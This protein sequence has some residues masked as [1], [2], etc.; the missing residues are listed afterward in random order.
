MKSN[1]DILERR[2]L[3]E[4]VSKVDVSVQKSSFFDFNHFLTN[5]AV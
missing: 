1:Y 5:E 4:M 2:I 3:W